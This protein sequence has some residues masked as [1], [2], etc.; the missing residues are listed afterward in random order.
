M[1]TTM[2]PAPPDRT[3]IVRAAVVV[4]VGLP[5]IADAYTVTVSATPLDD[6][7]MTESAGVAVGIILISLAIL[8]AG[9]TV[10]WAYAKYRAA[11][12]SPPPSSSWPP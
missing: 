11:G 6:R 2:V 8:H 7:P 1:T 10:T 9:N 12:S 3:V 4:A 5:L